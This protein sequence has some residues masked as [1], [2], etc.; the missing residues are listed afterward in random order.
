MDPIIVWTERLEILYIILIVMMWYLIVDD[1]IFWYGL[2]GHNSYYNLRMN[3]ASNNI[4]LGEVLGSSE[5]QDLLTDF[6]NLDKS[7]RGLISIT[8]AIK[9]LRE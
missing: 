7:K 4:K 1:K 8:D 6:S 3:G 9:L 5:L 2:S